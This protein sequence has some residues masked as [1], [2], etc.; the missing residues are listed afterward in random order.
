MKRIPIMDIDTTS[1]LFLR[2]CHHTLHSKSVHDKITRQSCQRVDDNL[3][4]PGV[5]PK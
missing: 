3:T 5:I 4:L 1:L 2:T